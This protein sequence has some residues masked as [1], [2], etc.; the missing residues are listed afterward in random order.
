MGN[1][2]KSIN[3]SFI[4]KIP[5]YIICKHGKSFIEVTKH[6]NNSKL[7]DHI[8]F[9]IVKMKEYHHHIILKVMINDS[10]LNVYD[11]LPLYINVNKIPLF[12]IMN[13]VLV[14]NSKMIEMIN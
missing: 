14:Y 7:G 12:Y 11:K 10:E 3:K 2:N 1:V 5:L 6:D 9:T 4:S 13:N 8:I